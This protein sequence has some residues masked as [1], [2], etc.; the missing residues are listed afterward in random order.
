MR[1]RLRRYLGHRFN[2]LATSRWARRANSAE[3]MAL[4]ALRRLRGQ[5]RVLRWELD[6]FLYVADGRLALPLMGSNAMQLPLYTE[7]AY[8]PELWRGPLPEKG[9][10]A[11]PKKTMIGSEATFFHDCE[12]SELTFRQ[13]RNRSEGDLAPFG[14]RLEIFRFDGS[15]LSLSVEMPPESFTGLTKRHLVRLDYSVDVERPLKVFARLNV[16]HG[17]N[18]EQIVRE[19]SVDGAEGAVEFDLAYSNLNEKRTEKLWVDLIFEDPGMNQ[20]ILRDATLSRRLR[21]EL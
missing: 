4:P 13:I 17:P 5:A 19:M 21:A 18:L 15:F 3:R 9:A 20:I 7:W 14:L 10:S 1:T 6:R 8:R 11:M 12:V 16:Q 2:Q